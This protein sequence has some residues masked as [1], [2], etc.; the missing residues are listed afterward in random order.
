MGYSSFNYLGKSIFNSLIDFVRGDHYNE[1]I[2]IQKSHLIKDLST[3]QD[4]DFSAFGVGLP[5]R[6]ILEVFDFHKKHNDEFSKLVKKY[7]FSQVI[8]SQ[9]LTIKL[10]ERHKELIKNPK[11][12][13]KEFLKNFTSTFNHKPYNLLDALRKIEIQEIN[14]A[15]DVSFSIIDIGIASN[16][17][18]TNSITLYDI[19]YDMI[20]N[21]IRKVFLKNEEYLKTYLPLNQERFYYEGVEKLIL[22]ALH[23]KDYKTDSLIPQ[24]KT[25]KL[26]IGYDEIWE[27]IHNDE[28]SLDYPEIYEFELVEAPEFTEYYID[29]KGNKVSVFPPPYKTIPIPNSKHKADFADI[30]RLS[31]DPYYNN[32]GLYLFQSEIHN[33]KKVDEII[34]KQ[35]NEAYMLILQNNF[36]TQ[37]I[38]F[39]SLRVKFREDEE[40]REEIKKR[41][42]SGDIVV[43]II[44]DYNATWYGWVLSREAFLAFRFNQALALGFLN[45]YDKETNG[46]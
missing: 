24:A 11:L 33:S 17:F 36:H 35:A 44:M 10:Y 46:I 41:S 13:Y 32:A 18:Y 43:P 22:N 28:T 16:L 34:H 29:E 9:W 30:I 45:A 21:S 6:V 39:E 26:G 19:I 23:L 2:N 27:L 3:L 37:D 4:N 15:N 38:L 1:S 40:F 5:K 20:P 42:E 12:E 25:N 7:P 31:A 8:F 14:Y